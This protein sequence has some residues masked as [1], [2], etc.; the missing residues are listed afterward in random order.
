MVDRERRVRESV[1]S[2]LS[3]TFT[4]VSTTHITPFFSVVTSY[5][6]C[7]M[8]HIVA[9]I[10]Q[11]SLEFVDLLLEKYPEQ[12][13]TVGSQVLHNFLEQISV[14]KDSASGLTIRTLAIT[15]S[16]SL[17]TQSWRISVL[18]RM[19][20]FLSAAVNYWKSCDKKEIGSKIKEVHWDGK[21]PLYVPI[22][23]TGPFKPMLLPNQFTLNSTDPFALR[24]AL[25][26]P[27]VLTNF[28]R[29]LIPLL[30]E[31]WIEAQPGHSSRKGTFIEHLCRKLLYLWLY[32]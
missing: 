18:Q 19:E 13:V 1:L 11:S 10:R 12:T 30:K 8:T 24:N 9:E 25:R 2:L 14:E 15:P 32:R 20:K 22:Y 3:L 5:L 7:A 29:I 31:T 4:H 16:S 28:V 23:N 26:D 6:S 17:S 21:S 27:K